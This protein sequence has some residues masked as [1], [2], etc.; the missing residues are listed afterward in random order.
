[1]DREAAFGL[2]RKAN[3]PKKAEGKR[4]TAPQEITK[5]SN[6][7]ERAQSEDM[8]MSVSP[9]CVKDGKKYAF[10]RFA[11]GSKNCEW[12]I[13]EARLSSN[14]GFSEEEISGLKFYIKNNMTDL[15][16]MA[17]QIN[18]FEVFKNG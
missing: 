8:T 17:A 2:K 10:V 11:D 15:K 1:M 5:K 13:P 4:R 16:R 18:L 14:E 9:I 12:T 3:S 7:K 6:M